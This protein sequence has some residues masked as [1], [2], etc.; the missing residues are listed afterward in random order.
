MCFIWIFWL[1]LQFDNTVASYCVS[2]F[3]SL[4]VCLVIEMP[5]SILQKQLFARED[6]GDQKEKTSTIYETTEAEAIK[7]SKKIA[8]CEGG[9]EKTTKAFT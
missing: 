6:E 1:Q 2:Y 5:F 8:D 4:I 7:L 9:G 3:L